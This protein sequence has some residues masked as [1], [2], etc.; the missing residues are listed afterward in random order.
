MTE[1]QKE[2]LRIKKEFLERLA[3]KP[4]MVHGG[5]WREIPLN[6]YIKFESWARPVINPDWE[7]VFRKDHNE[8]V[9]ETEETGILSPESVFETDLWFLRNRAGFDLSVRSAR[10]LR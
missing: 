2:L 3:K 8:V 7:E 10:R 4:V 6:Q 5:E 1:K 9:G